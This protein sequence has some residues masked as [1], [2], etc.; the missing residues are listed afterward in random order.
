[1]SFYIVV[2][3]THTIGGI[4]M[5]FGTIVYI[6]RGGHPKMRGREEGCYRLTRA[7]YIGAHGNFVTCRLLEDD[8]YSV[9]G[10]DKKGDVYNWDRSAVLPVRMKSHC[11]AHT[12]DGFGPR[13]K[14]LADTIIFIRGR[15]V[16]LCAKHLELEQ[17]LLD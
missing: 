3:I 9:H 8:P 4:D 13:C 10:L 15:R 17:R 1:M 16:E 5:K 7:V 2:I 14:R 11:M 12:K 6:R